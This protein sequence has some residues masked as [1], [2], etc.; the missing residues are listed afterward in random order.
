MCEMVTQY[1]CR[2]CKKSYPRNGFPHRCQTCG[3]V[4]ELTEIQGLDIVKDFTHLP[5]IWKYLPSFGLTKSTFINY[6][7]EGNTPLISTQQNSKEVFYKLES[8]NPTGSYKDRGSAILT[9]VLRNRGIKTSIEDSSG[10]AGASFAAYAA[11]AGIQAT[12]YVPDSASGPKLGQIEA[13]G[14]QVIPVRGPREN[15]Y[16]AALE[17]A[18]KQCTPY[19]SHA[20]IPFGMSGIATIAYEIVDQMGKSPDNI[21][22][23]IGHGSLFLGVM[24]GFNAMLNVGKIIQ[25]PR[26]I[27][28]QPKSYS[29]LVAKKAGL[30]FY[31]SGL[32]TLAEGTKIL[33]PT[34][35]DSILEKMTKDDLILA[36]EENDLICAYKKLSQLGIFVEPT[37]ALVQAGYDMIKEKL[38]GSCVLILTGFGLKSS[39]LK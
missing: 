4:F 39:V 24:L 16:K 20:Y 18:E 11:S 23:P 37:S 29:P 13:Y 25:L 27:G 34:R 35:G 12:V 10:N 19:A 15:A 1:I 22:M 33:S 5:G 7:G 9:S 26:F 28:V 14:A 17:A 30:P 31:A 2:Q 38:T 8:L 36:I 32:P 3:G 21:F 6:L